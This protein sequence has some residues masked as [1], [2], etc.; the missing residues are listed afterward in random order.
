MNGGAP[1]AGRYEREHLTGHVET[2]GWQLP[3]TPPSAD[4]SQTLLSAT[5]GF[6]ID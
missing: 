6:R 1:H 5:V 3:D 4:Y 2:Q